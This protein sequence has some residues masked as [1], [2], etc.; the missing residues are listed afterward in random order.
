MKPNF[1]VSRTAYNN[2]R[3]QKIT[4]RPILQSYGK[5]VAE[6]GPVEFRNSQEKDEKKRENFA[7]FEKLQLKKL[8]GTAEEK[9]QIMAQYHNE[10]QQNQRIYQEKIVQEKLIEMRLE[11]EMIEREKYE[12][13]MDK[14]KDAAMKEYQEYLRAVQLS[15]IQQKKINQQHDKLQEVEADKQ[16]GEFFKEHFGKSIR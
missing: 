8:H 3:L 10:L 16:R 14:E 6:N 15:Q 1:T 13:I 11:Q 2:Q 9:Q 12:Q 4:Q 5:S 7:E